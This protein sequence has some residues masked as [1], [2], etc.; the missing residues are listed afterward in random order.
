M[1]YPA[2]ADYPDNKQAWFELQKEYNTAQ[3]KFQRT[4][5]KAAA[6]DRTKQMRDA[7]ARAEAA[8]AAVVE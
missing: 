8:E 2:K 4:G 6:A 5:T 3:N 1:K 7:L